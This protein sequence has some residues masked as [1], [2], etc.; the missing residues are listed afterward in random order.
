MSAC[1]RA[2]CCF[3]SAS[4]QVFVYRLPPRQS[5]RA[6]R[7]DDW[8]LDKPA[9]TCRLKVTSKVS[10]REQGD[11]F[12]EERDGEI[13]K[14]AAKCKQHSSSREV[15]LTRMTG[16][17]Q[18]TTLFVALQDQQTGELFAECPIKTSEELPRCIEPVSDS[19]RYFVIRVVNQSQCN[20][21]SLP[22][23]SP[24]LYLSLRGFSPRRRVCSESGSK[25]TEDHCPPALRCGVRCHWCRP[26]RVPRH[27]LCRAL[28]RV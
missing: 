21:L 4:L 12:G 1:S 11:G 23:P 7:A 3:S 19:S 9:W 6:Y 16:F 20:A 10:V 2:V 24:S 18:G 14:T 27:W 26:A 22:S 5:N 28:G 15:V 25:L 17:L 8:G 13:T